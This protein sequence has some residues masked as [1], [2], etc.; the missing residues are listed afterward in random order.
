MNDNHNLQPG[1]TAVDL[2]APANRFALS[3][4]LYG[5][6]HRWWLLLGR[7]WW[8]LALLMSAMLLPV[9][10]ISASLG[11]AYESK[12]RMWI[13]GKLD[14]YE[15]RVYTEELIDFLGT[16]AE[17][18][19]SPV[20]ENQA[21]ARLKGGPVKPSIGAD[22]ARPV[23]RHFFWA[24]DA[25][26]PFPFK[27]KVVEGA[28]SSTLELRAIGAD[29]EATR[30]FLDCL[31]ESYL[32]FKKQSREGTSDRTLA[33]MSGG[34]SQLEKQLEAQQE[35]MHEF[36]VSNN[37]VFLQEQGN[38]ASSYLAQLNKQLAT[39]H[40][41]LRL[42]QALHPDQWVEFQARHSD[43]SGE[44]S[45][46]AQGASQ[47][48]LASLA[49]PQLE[50]FKANQQVQLLK[51]KRD[52]L[53]VFL[54]P[55]HPKIAKLNEDIATQEKLAQIS[56]DEAS[57]QMVHRRQAVEL[58]IQNLEAAFQEWDSRAIEASRKIADYDRIRQ[59]LQRMQ[60]G[61]DKL[62]GLIQTVD[63]NKK[64][65]QENV[66]ILEHA[67]R[68]VSTHRTLKNM[69]IAL[70]GSVLLSV[71]L[72]Y[73]LGLFHD[74]FASLM[75]LEGQLY[76]QVIGQIPSI[77]L[78]E[79]D[80]KP[81]IASVHQQRFEFLESFRSLR[82]SLMFMGN[83]RP[84]PKTIL[85]ASSVPEEGKSTVALYLAATIAMADSRVLLIDAD[86]RR[87]TLHKFVGAASGPGLAE[88]LSRKISF[89]QAIVQTG[90]ENL[91][92]LPAGEPELNP[93]ELVLSPM[94]PRFL[95]E[96]KEQYDYIIVDTPPVLAADDASALATKMDGV[97]FV[98]R[99]SYTAARMAS[100]ALDLLRQ[101]HA[102]VLG[103]VF[104]R[105]VSSPYEHHYYQSYRNAYRWK[106]SK[107]GSAGRAGELLPETAGVVSSK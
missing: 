5:A 107:S 18:L 68:A 99:G 104:N 26:P 14:I 84:K 13:T 30:A 82:S 29:P 60:A 75:E 76:T 28:K 80:G 105:V 61:Y 39:L 95:E 11:P 8:A 93:G 62:L 16:Q 67:S 89:K 38:S 1:T 94:W 106:P 36:Q 77:M 24:S 70:F 97:L 58:E 65:E 92:F 22:P 40:T 37:V 103:L 79:A 31:M 54:R 21:L 47:D 56:R 50:L 34:V 52:E 83:G 9:Y 6:L 88:I 48:F 91:S 63:V 41:E 44:Q 87:A 71:G 3:S 96:I 25:P 12:A 4:K 78:Q 33:G 49:G 7:Y 46:A 45:T 19:H 73:V 86:M 15:G 85:V 66:E 53:S 90:F 69:A 72:L 35:K 43:T 17:L 102:H 98:V 55:L 32:E 23:K 101:R 42:L 10:F 81:G 59:D 64:M 100:G 2:L 20:I 57:K 51:A 27:V 74:D